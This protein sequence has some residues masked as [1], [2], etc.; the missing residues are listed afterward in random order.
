MLSEPRHLVRLLCDRASQVL[1]SDRRRSVQ[2][3]TTS[4]PPALP[5][6]VA[7]PEAL[8]N[9]HTRVATELVATHYSRQQPPTA[10]YLHAHDRLVDL[11]VHES[12]SASC[13]VPEM[14][15]RALLDYVH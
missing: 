10:L 6:H 15:H 7:S 8:D 4:D 5:S 13:T 2:C 11:D 1:D 12:L 14:D 3:R 9:T